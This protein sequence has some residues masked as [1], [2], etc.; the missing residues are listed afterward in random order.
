MLFLAVR[1]VGEREKQVLVTDL[2]AV[3]GRQ[4]GWKVRKAGACNR[5]D[6]CFRT[7]GRLE[8]VKARTCNRPDRCFRLSGR[9]ESQEEG[10]GNRP[11]V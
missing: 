2:S 10:V 1:S 3:F 9:L 5:P 11:R 6:C 8:R 7:S 4:V